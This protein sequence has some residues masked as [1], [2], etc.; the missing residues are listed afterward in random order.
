VTHHPAACSHAS[1]AQYHSSA[2][3][4]GW[5]VP[6]PGMLAPEDD[7]ARWSAAGRLRH[8]YPGW[9]VLWL[10]RLGQFRAYRV[11]GR[12]RRPVTLTAAD[13]AALA[14]QITAAEKVPGRPP[15]GD[16]TP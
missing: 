15:P 3:H 5:P 14:A 1:P 7:A 10:A 4:L 16:N 12:P 6:A 11:S 8:E 9:L 13:P 2:A